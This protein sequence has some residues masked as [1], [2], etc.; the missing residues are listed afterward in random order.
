[1]ALFNSIQAFDVHWFRVINIGWEN[2]V[3]DVI[4]PILTYLGSSGVIWLVLA[5]LIAYAGG[6]AGRG[7][8]VAMMCALVLSY[9]LTEELLKNLFARPRPFTV[10]SDARVLISKPLTYSFPSG[11]AAVSFACA[12]VLIRGCKRLWWFFLVLAISIALS[13]VY[14]GVHYPLDVIC[15]SVVGLFCGIFVIRIR[16]SLSSKSYRH[17]PVSRGNRRRL[18]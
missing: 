12:V 14:V 6:K 15:G 5:A 10:I 2:K 18:K 7:V 8:A 17:R 4:M 11:H 1:M 16:K 3:L 9:F 13:R